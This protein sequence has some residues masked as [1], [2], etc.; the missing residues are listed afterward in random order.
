MFQISKY[1]CPK[2]KMYLF[3]I[4]KCICFKF[5]NMFVPKL[6]YI[7]FKLTS[8]QNCKITKYIYLFRLLLWHLDDHFG[9]VVGPLP[10]AE[11]LLYQHHLNRRPTNWRE[12]YS[13]KRNQI[14]ITWIGAQ[15]TV[16]GQFDHQTFHPFSYLFHKIRLKSFQSII[17]TCNVT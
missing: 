9:V 1:I 4:Q 16:K 17:G 5:Q 13:C 7:C 14:K 3:Q 12:G 15:Q 8:L 6:K 2:I 11:T 10:L